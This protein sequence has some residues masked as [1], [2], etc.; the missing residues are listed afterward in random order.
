LPIF[1]ICQLIEE[2]GTPLLVGYRPKVREQ[3]ALLR[4]ELPGI[5]WFFAVKANDQIDL[6]KTIGE[7]GVGFDIAT[8]EEW[9][10]VQE[11][12]SLCQ[13]QT[14]ENSDQPMIVHSHPCKSPVDLVLCYR[15]GV[16]RFV[17][18]CQ[19]E[20]SKIAKYAPDSKCLLRINVP[21]NSSKVNLSNRFGADIDEV[22]TLLS[23][24]RSLN[25]RLDGL[26]FHVGSQAVN[27]IDFDEALSL[28]RK[29][30]D[31]IVLDG[32][33]LQ[34][35]DIGGG[36]PVSYRLQTVPSLREYCQRIRKSLD[37]SFGDLNL[38]VIAEP[39]RIVCAE[40][41]WLVTS[42]IG[43]Q[44]RNE[45][46]WYTIDDGRYG[47]FSGR[48]FTEACFDFFPLQDLKTEIKPSMIVGPTC[49]GG[50]IIATDYL[51]PVLELGDL[52]VVPNVGAYCAVGA[53]RFNGMPL[54]KHAWIG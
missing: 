9:R 29:A 4:Q 42:I 48:Y 38:T 33:P 3:I 27:P 25:L 20:V 23:H 34:T 12:Y 52:L 39:G 37:R 1:P 26:A 2:H 40:A 36:F 5:D 46:W 51:L 28:A 21:G 54:A 16:R 19:S 49:D 43:K 11:A 30:W 22:R 13:P 14:V 18:D 6:L 50:D 15:N 44:Y 45:R 17:F 24:A 8:F 32:Y 10:R 31:Q 7:A 41:M 35:L 53:T 47:T